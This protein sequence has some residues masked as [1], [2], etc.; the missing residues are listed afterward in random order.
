MRRLLTLFLIFT[1]VIANGSSV[2]NAICHH[3]SLADHIAARKSDDARI[4]GMAFSEEAADLVASK[5][6]AVANTGAIAWIANLSPGP[7]LTVPLDLTHPAEHAMA[8]VRPL[9]G[10]SLAPLLEPPAA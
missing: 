4:S 9:S 7:Q 6:G 2:A 5:K 10:R 8:V 1:L 3:Q